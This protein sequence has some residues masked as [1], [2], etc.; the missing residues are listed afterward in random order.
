MA[1]E[2]NPQKPQRRSKKRA[3]SAGR[4]D[5]NEQTTQA[6]KV[7]REKLSQRKGVNMP[8]LI[9]E[10][11]GEMGVDTTK[12]FIQLLDDRIYFDVHYYAVVGL[13]TLAEL[14]RL[15]VDY[16]RFFLDKTIEIA[17]IFGNDEL[18]DSIDAVIR[19]RRTAYP[20][21]GFI[22]KLILEE[23]H[24]PSCRWIAFTTVASIMQYKSADIPED[25]KILLRQEADN[26]SDEE[27]KSRYREILAQVY[28]YN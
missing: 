4:Q 20:L 21:I 28:S 3:I 26:E 16:V 17:R 9:Q 15:S 25:L 22:K 8:L 23:G 1:A 14:E 24:I 13:R 2:K 27:K 12:A 5:M 7:I 19:S 10:L 6:A 11:E 18:Y